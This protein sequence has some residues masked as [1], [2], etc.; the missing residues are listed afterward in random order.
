MLCPCRRLTC[1]GAFCNGLDGLR[2]VR[3]LPPG[4]GFG[5]AQGRSFS[6]IR[7]AGPRLK[8]GLTGSTLCCGDLRILISGAGIR[9]PDFGRCVEFDVRSKSSVQGSRKAATPVQVVRR[10]R[11]GCLRE[12]GI[13]SPPAM[14]P[15]LL[16]TGQPGHRAPRDWS[17]EPYPHRGTHPFG[18]SSASST[19]STSALPDPGVV[20]GPDAAFESAPLPCSGDGFV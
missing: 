5:P 6:A 11:D 9:R 14:R 7:S 18:N 10:P 15:V 12:A 8:Q 2:R 17:R 1:G 19:P 4:S 20:S 16:T 13:S 3:R